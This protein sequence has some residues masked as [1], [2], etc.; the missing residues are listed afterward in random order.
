MERFFAYLIIFLGFLAIGEELHAKEEGAN[1]PAEIT[2]ILA[3]GVSEGNY[4]GSGKNI[5]A[6]L[7]EDLESSRIVAIPSEGSIDNL[8]RLKEGAADLIIVQRDELTEAYY[9]ESN[10]FNDLE[11][12]LP[13][14]PEALQIFV[15]GETGV[16]DYDIFADKVRSGAID[17][18]ALPATGSTTYETTRSVLGIQGLVTPHDFLRTNQKGKFIDQFLEGNSPA[19]AF[20]SANPVKPLAGLED[21]TFAVVSFDQQGLRTLDQHLRNLD[22]LTLTNSGYSSLPPEAEIHTL[23]TW[24]LL[25]ARRGFSE[26]LRKTEGVSLASTVIRKA[27]ED[28]DGLL[29]PTFTKNDAFRLEHQHGRIR[30]RGE[31]GQIARF[32]RGMALSDD[33]ASVF[34]R[35]AIWG[36]LLRCLVLGLVI[37]L[38]LPIIRRHP[39]AVNRIWL[40][41]SGIIWGLVA[42]AIV[43]WFAPVAVFWLERQY[44]ENNAVAS[45]ILDLSEWER[46]IWLFV[47]STTGYESEVFPISPVARYAAAASAFL[48]YIIIVV[49]IGATFVSNWSRKRRRNGMCDIKWKNH[50]VVCGWNEGAPQIVESL[51][52]G[53]G[54]PTSEGHHVVVVFPDIGRLLDGH[55]LQKEIDRGKRLRLVDG[56]A[57]FE[58]YLEQANIRQAHTTVLLSDDGSEDPD[59]RTLL[60][61]LAIS[62]YTQRYSKREGKDARPQEDDLN[63]IVAEVNNPELAPSLKQNHVNE[64]VC[65]REFGGNVLVQTC[66]YHGV[67]EI[68]GNLLR[69]DDS[70]NEFYCISLQDKPQLH[71]RTY[72]ELAPKLRKVGILL[73]GVKAAFYEPDGNGGHR[74]IIDRDRVE[75][76]LQHEGNI[77]RFLTK[78]NRDLKLSRQVMINPRDDERKY[79]TDNDDELFVL[80]FNRK[81]LTAIEKVRFTSDS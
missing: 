5:A 26:Q 8:R 45:P 70:T 3:T 77:E 74:E 2:Y 55:P 35:E 75:Q 62:R 73:L 66:F 36:W 41:Y 13:L 44:C 17:H 31:S 1:E 14:F 16:L 67:T 29:A 64:V 78:G 38:A 81:Q 68:V 52:R 71:N 30:L 76:I 65:T 46:R 6:W 4:Y 57:K 60:R 69:Y 40:H 7:N 11:I 72:D 9:N 50:T 22:A 56:D 39:K 24:A 59:E 80:A 10:P 51:L 79:R 21:F 23:G 54:C 18:L 25:V 28:E 27:L 47:W 37:A 48:N 53:S 32:F 19:V 15:S 43:A 49:A 58:P 12:L 33:L 20:F 42:F 61:A 63:Y 34:G